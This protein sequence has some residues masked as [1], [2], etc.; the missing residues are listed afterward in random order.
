MT[1]FRLLPLQRADALLL[2]RDHFFE[3][4]HALLLRAHG[5]QGLFEAFAQ[6]LIGPA[7]ACSNWSSVRSNASYKMRLSLRS[8][9]SSSSVVMPL[10]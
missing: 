7:R 3:G 2:G 5:D 4:L 1:I 6:I 8:W 10:L 9:A